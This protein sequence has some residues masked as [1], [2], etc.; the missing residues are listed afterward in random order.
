MLVGNK[1]DERIFDKTVG[2]HVAGGN[3]VT[4]V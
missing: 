2:V 3:E 1:G 4:D